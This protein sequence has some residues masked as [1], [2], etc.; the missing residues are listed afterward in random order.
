[1]KLTRM[2]KGTKKKLNS[3][4]FKNQRIIYLKDL[5][6][7]PVM[8]TFLDGGGIMF[9]YEEGKY[10]NEEI[11]RQVKHFLIDVIEEDESANI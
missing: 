1:M 6:N 4:D 9:E 7:L 3:I 8:L 10:P 11:E 2:K 5:N